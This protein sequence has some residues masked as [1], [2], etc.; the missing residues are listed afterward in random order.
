MPKYNERMAQWKWF[1][2]EFKKKTLFLHTKFQQTDWDVS[3]HNWRYGK[4]L[5]DNVKNLGV[6]FDSRISFEHH[7]KI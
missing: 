1:E 5:E 4:A 2:N 7:I 6:L 3:K